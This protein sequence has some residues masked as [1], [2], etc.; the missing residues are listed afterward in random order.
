[1]C[2]APILDPLKLHVQATQCWRCLSFHRAVR[3]DRRGNFCVF[4]T[5]APLPAWSTHRACFALGQLA[6]C[7]DPRHLYAGS[8]FIYLL[9][10][11]LISPRCASPRFPPLY[12]DIPVSTEQSLVAPIKG[13]TKAFLRAAT[14]SSVP[15]V[16]RH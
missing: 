5:A 6:A 4:P 16:G 10:V 9:G 1:M 12:W 13:Q 7:L 2:L 3:V 8:C 14:I 11:L 15:S